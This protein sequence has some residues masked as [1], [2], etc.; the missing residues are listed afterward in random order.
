MESIKSPLSIRIIYWL[1]S[2][3]LVMMIIVSLAA[4]VFNFM[5]YTK[6]FEGDSNM[7]LHTDLPV[8]VDFLEIGKL[9][10]NNQSVDVQLV[11]A[12][13]RIHFFNTPLFITRKVAPVIFLLVSGV[14]YMIWIFRNFIKN[15]K[16]GEIFNIKNI[17]L[18]KHLS[19]G[20][21]GLWLFTVVYMRIFYYYIVKNLEFENVRITE[22]IP[23]HSGLL[24][25]ALLIWVLAHIFITGL[26]LQEEKDLTI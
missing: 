8:K 25:T 16:N 21:V 13:S 3:S 12:T 20:M 26:K 24:F 6:F 7:Q 17:T 19:Y 5:L 15:V 1:T 9:R 18:L 4:I 10:L 11:E 2:F 22:E 14:V 23:N